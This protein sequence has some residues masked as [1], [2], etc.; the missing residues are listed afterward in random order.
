MKRPKSEEFFGIYGP[1]H[2]KNCCELSLAVRRRRKLQNFGSPES[3][4]SHRRSQF[5]A[6]REFFAAL[7]SSYQDLCIDTLSTF[8]TPRVLRLHVDPLPPGDRDLSSSVKR[9]T[10]AR[11]LDSGT[12]MVCG[13]CGGVLS[14]FQLELLHA[15]HLKNTLGT[16]PVECGPAFSYSLML[17]AHLSCVLCSTAL[18]HAVP[19][20]G[21]ST[22]HLRAALA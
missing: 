22:S 18:P 19:V 12:P 11:M 9:N 21:E 10:G 3:S 16:P 7:Q 13:T 8:T 1:F 4:G 15:R 2:T 5:G 14:P 17:L 20:E 6:L